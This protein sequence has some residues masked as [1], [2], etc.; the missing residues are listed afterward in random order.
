MNELPG[1]IIEGEVVEDYNPAPE[2]GDV[3]A[4]RMMRTLDEL[5]EGTILQSAGED[6]WDVLAYR[7]TTFEWT[8]TGI[9]RSVTSDK[10]GQFAAAWTVI[11]PGGLT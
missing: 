5:P 4:S 11:R 1:P 7:C 6:D 9:S 10:L 2:C 8:V 3:I